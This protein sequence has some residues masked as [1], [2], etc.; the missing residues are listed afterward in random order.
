MPRQVFRPERIAFVEE[1]DADHA[2][3][4]VVRGEI[5]EAMLE[6]LA[7]FIKRQRARLKDNAT[8]TVAVK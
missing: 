7:R 8:K 1:T 3:R 6:G 4:L 5:T 2:M